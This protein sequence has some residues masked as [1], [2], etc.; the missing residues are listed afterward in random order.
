MTLSTWTYMIHALGWS[1]FGLAVGVWLDTIGQA[2]ARVTKPRTTE[3]PVP[4]RDHHPQ[5][6]PRPLRR[7]ATP[8][9]VLVVLALVS[10]LQGVWF[11]WTNQA[12]D[13]QDR[14]ILVCQAAYANGFADAIE[15]RSSAAA[16]AQAASDELWITIGQLTT[17]TAAGTPEAGKQFRT[18]LDKYLARRAEANKQQREN[19]YP[20]APRDLC[21]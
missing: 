1:L 16:A 2:V 3:E 13:D 18:A 4:D 15:A 21:K 11:Q 5:T 7:L 19:P 9:T 14:R 17:G 12:Q 6:P 20:P 8:S 10:A